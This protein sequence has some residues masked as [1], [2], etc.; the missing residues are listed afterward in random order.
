LLQHVSSVHIISSYTVL[1]GYSLMKDVLSPRPM[2]SFTL[3]YSKT[4][5]S[6][7]IFI[8]VFKVFIKITVKFDLLRQ[9]MVW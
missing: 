6:Y 1:Q 5:K 3:L 9:M 4:I 8:A 7:Q 2:V